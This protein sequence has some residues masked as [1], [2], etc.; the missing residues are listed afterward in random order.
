MPT[1]AGISLQNG[2]QIKWL[3]TEAA[4]GGVLY[5]KSV[6]KNFAKFTEKH[7][8]QSLFF[9]KVA[10]LKSATLTLFRIGGGKK[11]HFPVFPL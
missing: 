10:V 2:A 1:K 11:A 3:R 7:L 8:C 6:L 4:T 9:D 5:K